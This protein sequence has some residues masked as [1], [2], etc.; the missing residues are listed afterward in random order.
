MFFFM[1]SI[2]KLRPEAAGA[3]GRR[4]QPDGA[5]PAA[6]VGFIEVFQA[7]GIFLGRMPSGGLQ[8]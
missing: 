5:A 2:I 4:A 1:D 7:N 8:T 6:K 3:G